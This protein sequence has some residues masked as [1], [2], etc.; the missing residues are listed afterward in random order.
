M[1]LDIDYNLLKPKLVQILGEQAL[2]NVLLSAEIE[3]LNIE[4]ATLKKKEEK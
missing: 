2:Q 4:L 1:I 3:R